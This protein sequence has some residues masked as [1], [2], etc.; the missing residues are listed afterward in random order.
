[1]IYEYEP[2]CK[3][4]SSECLWLRLNI[5]GVNMRL[6]VLSVALDKYLT[7]ILL[8]WTRDIPL[9]VKKKPFMKGFLL[10]FSAEEGCG[11]V[12]TCRPPLDPTM[13]VYSLTWNMCSLSKGEIFF[14]KKHISLERILSRVMPRSGTFFR[15][16]EL[17][18]IYG[19]NQLLF[20]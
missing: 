12:R 10:H 7:I 6:L 9:N 18:Y 2:W 17:R 13:R 19:D 4:W 3:L 5:L 1:M 8:P 14:K 11:G 16:N 20:I 15:S